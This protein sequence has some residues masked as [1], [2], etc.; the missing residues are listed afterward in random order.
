MISSE[1]FSG[2]EE[3]FFLRFKATQA[4]DT[5]QIAP[6]APSQLNNWPLFLFIK[7]WQKGE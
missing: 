1:I 3:V 5:G 2:S 6:F 4:W 7:F